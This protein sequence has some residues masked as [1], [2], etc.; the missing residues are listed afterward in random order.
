MYSV[1]IWIN[2]VLSDGKQSSTVC[3]L[4]TDTEMPM[5]PIVGESLSFYQAKGSALEFHMV[6]SIGILRN[7]SVETNVEDVRHYAV[8]GDN[9]IVYRTAL[10]CSEIPVASID[11]ARTVCAFMTSQLGFEVDPYGVNKLGN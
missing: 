5:R 8:K 9:G 1:E 2:V 3:T 7:S 10:H 6:S 11:D 4:F